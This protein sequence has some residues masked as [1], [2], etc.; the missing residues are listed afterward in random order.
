VTVSAG[1]S[2][3]PAFTITTSAV[4]NTTPVTISATYNG[5]TVNAPLSV[6][7]PPA[8]GS[9]VLQLHADAS[10]VSGT[11]NGAVVTPTIA[12]AG[13]TGTVVVASGGSVN[14]TPA[15]SGN[16]VY[17]LN[18]CNNTSNAYYKFTGAALGNVFNVSQG[19]ITF[20]LKSRYSF[21]QRKATATGQRY[22]FDV[23]GGG[24]THLFSFMTQVSS[25]SLLFTSMASGATNYYYV[26]AGT[27]DALFG[28]GALLQVTMTWGNGVSNLYLNGTLV[29]SVAF[30]T[31]SVTWNAAANFDLGAFEYLNFGGYDSSDDVIDEFTVIW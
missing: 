8:S 28:N 26:P 7:P 6:T 1:A 12:P 4:T 23:R 13:L 10:E 14:F 20:Y 31:P 9:P 30:S 24:G 16:G 17:F 22:A 11:Q 2:A 19:Q 25:G 15:A 18:C 5:V 21:A 29:K 27:E 3:S